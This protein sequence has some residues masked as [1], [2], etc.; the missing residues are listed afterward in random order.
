MPYNIEYVVAT[1]LSLSEALEIK[2]E[3]EALENTNGNG[4]LFTYRIEEE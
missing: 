1:Q 3:F 2:L 4:D